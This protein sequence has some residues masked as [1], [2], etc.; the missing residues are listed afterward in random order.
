MFTFCLFGL[1]TTSTF[2]MF[3]CIKIGA[4]AKLS[5][6]SSKSEESRTTIKKES[7]VQ[8]KKSTQSAERRSRQEKHAKPKKVREA[9]FRFDLSPKKNEED[10]KTDLKSLS[11]KSNPFE[12]KYK[13]KKRKEIEGKVEQAVAIAGEKA[14]DFSVYNMDKVAIDVEQP[15]IKASR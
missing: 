6:S 9:T 15:K 1:F 11:E 3:Q 12:K 4:D 8:T 10:T 2:L 7:S 13:E 14:K 5:N